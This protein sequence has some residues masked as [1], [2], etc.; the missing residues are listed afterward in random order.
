[1]SVLNT[2]SELFQIKSEGKQ[3]P[4]EHRKAVSGYPVD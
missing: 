1:V 4:A 2:D 3:E